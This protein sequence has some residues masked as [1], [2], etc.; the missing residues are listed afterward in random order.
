MIAEYLDHQIGAAVHDLRQLGEILGG[1]DE[2]P[3]AHASDDAVEI[4]GERVLEV[5]EEIEPAEA[6]GL[7]ALLDR[8]LTAELAHEAPL[9][10]PYR[11]LA[12][13]EQQIAAPDEGHIVAGDLAGLR[14]LDADLSETCLDPTRHGAP[15]V[16]LAVPPA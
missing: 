12:R 14:Q 6:R 7:L 15:L 11:Q 10:H 16:V 4:A 3:E 13:D 9:A 1:I 8:E 5:R 2:A